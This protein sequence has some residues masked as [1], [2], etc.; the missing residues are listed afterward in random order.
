MPLQV[1]NLANNALSSTLPASWSH[2]GAFASLQNLNLEINHLTGL[3]PDAWG[4]PEAFRQLS[5]LSLIY[6]KISGP[7][8]DSWGANGSLCELQNLWLSA[9]Q[10]SGSLSSVWGSSTGLE[11]LQVSVQI[12]CW[13]CC[14][15]MRGV[16]ILAHLP[17]S[18]WRALFCSASEYLI[19]SCVIDL[20]G[21]LQDDGALMCMARRSFSPYLAALLP[22]FYSLVASHI[23]HATRVKLHRSASSC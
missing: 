2:A 23:C 6:N 22:V 5:N 8:P 14:G 4:S 20:T 21:S 7:L 1:L 19:V 9:N 15:Q 17:P 3:L 10:L 12:V 16:G 13:V 18:G 11:S